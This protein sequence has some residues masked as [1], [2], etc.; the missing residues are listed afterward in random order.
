[1]NYLMKYNKRNPEVFQKNVDADTKR[2]GFTWRTTIEERSFWEDVLNGNFNLFFTKYP[3]TNQYPKVM[4]VSDSKETLEKG[5]GAI[6]VVF[7]EKCGQYLAWSSAE[8]LEDAKKNIDTVPWNCAKELPSIKELTMQEIADK[9]NIDVDC[10]K[11][12]K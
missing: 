5:N 9:F 6:R 4:M 8:T 2:G 12:K 10:L 11:I 1:M 3:K 7:M